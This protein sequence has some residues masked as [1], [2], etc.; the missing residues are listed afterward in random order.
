[1]GME[2]KQKAIDELNTVIK[3]CTRCRLCRTRKNVLVGEGNLQARLMLIAQAPGE[4]EDREGKTEGTAQCH[5]G[6]KLAIEVKASILFIIV[7]AR[8]KSQGCLLGD[9]LSSRFPSGE[10]GGKPLNIFIA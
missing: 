10:T 4:N 5:S 7:T 8:A 9:R 1:M 2:S 6:L 3:G